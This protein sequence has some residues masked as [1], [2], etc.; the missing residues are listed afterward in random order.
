MG[1]R[2]FTD[3][4][5]MAHVVEIVIVAVVLLGVAGFIAW[6][7][8]DANQK[9]SSTNSALQQALASAQCAKLN[10]KDLCKFLTIWQRGGTSKVTSTVTADNKTTVSTYETSDNGANYHLTM[11]VDGQPYEVVG[12][13]DTLYTKDNSDGKWWKQ[14]IDPNINTDHKSAYNY[15]FG[16]PSKA[17]DQPAASDPQYK[18]LGTEACGSKTC[19]KYQV[20]DPIVP[21][22]TQYIWFDNK[23]YQLQHLRTESK[24][25]AINEQVFVYSNA[26]VSAPSPTKDLPANTYIVPGQ[27]QPQTVPNVQDLQNQLDDE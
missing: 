6:R 17:S 22:D 20:I 24:D 14:T 16:D 2:K 13:G 27:S 3:Q 8:W 15:N 9:G 18:K 10:D 11:T 4:R 7:V 12:I 5:G 26:A 1:M 25:G 19:F 23:D 21:G